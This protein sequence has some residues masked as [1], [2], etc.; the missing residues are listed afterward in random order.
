MSFS[1]APGGADG[2][3]RRHGAVPA[4]AGC[5]LLQ[6]RRA[7]QSEVTRQDLLREAVTRY[8][9][10]AR[11]KVGRQRATKAQ[12]DKACWHASMHTL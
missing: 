4:A 9:V 11:R 10:T 7:E 12:Q 6:E 1:S 3:H 2:E 5:G 8:P